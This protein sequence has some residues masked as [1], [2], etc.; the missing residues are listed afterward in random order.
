MFP[1]SLGNVDVP[2]VGDIPGAFRTVLLFSGPA[3]LV[4]K[5]LRDAPQ[6]RVEYEVR[7]TELADALDSARSLILLDQYLRSLEHSSIEEP[8]NKKL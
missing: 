5:R 4:I 8:G 3:E 6:G 2:P 7:K 1:L